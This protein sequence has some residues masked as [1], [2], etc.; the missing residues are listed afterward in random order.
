[1]NTLESKYFRT[2][3][4]NASVKSECFLPN[5]RFRLKCDAEINNVLDAIAIYRV[6]KIFTTYTVLFKIVLH[7]TRCP[8]KELTVEALKLDTCLI[9][10]FSLRSS[11]N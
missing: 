9:S 10:R 6:R 2:R 11:S 5:K 1:M 7:Y 4:T 8:R 3:F